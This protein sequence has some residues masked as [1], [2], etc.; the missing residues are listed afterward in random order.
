MNKLFLIIFIMGIFNIKSAQTLPEEKITEYINTADKI[1]REAL[2]NKVGY[3]LLREL[4]QF[5]PRLSGSENMEKAIY[6][7]EEKMKSLGYDSVWLQPVM[8]P[9]WVRGEKEEAVILN[10]KHEGKKLSILALGGSVGTDENGISGEVIEVQNFD[11]L[12]EIGNKAKGKIIFFNR[13]FDESLIN[14]FQAYGA[15]VNQ[16]SVGAIEAAKVGAIGAIVR[17][18]TS[19]YD[20]IPHTG[21][22]RYVDSLPQIPAVAI[23]LIDADFLS[24]AIKEEPTLKV[25]IK[26]SCETLPDILS[27]NVIGDLI[28]SELPNEIVIVSGHFDS[29]D[30]GDGS[31]DDGGPCMQ[32]MEIPNLY[33]RLNIKPKRTIRCILFINEE[34]GVRGGIEYGIYADTTKEIHVAAIESDRGVFTPRGFSVDAD[35]F[36]IKQMQN[37]LPILNRSNIEWVRKGGSGV[38]ISRIKVAKALIGYVP[39]DQRYFDFHHSANDVF[40]EVNPRE[41]QLGT[42]AMAIL[43]LLLS[44]EGLE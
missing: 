32:A 11:E 37:W 42:A 15:A 26:L 16:R 4:V 9:Y 35:E 1:V 17:S 13:P 12:R 41:M 40:E 36:R 21:M 27:Y 2:S 10:S 34:N 7:A 25:N 30:V 22:M 24:N 18:V 31:H 39:D 5:G 33:K 28:G 43:T 44:E 14:T 6:W 8:V 3:E 29:W 19:K 38:D 20:N 23:G